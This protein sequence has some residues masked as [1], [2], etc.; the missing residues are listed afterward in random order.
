MSQLFQA[1]NLM[2]STGAAVVTVGKQLQT[3]VQAPAVRPFGIY[4]TS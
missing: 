3:R 1:L 2:R 4:S